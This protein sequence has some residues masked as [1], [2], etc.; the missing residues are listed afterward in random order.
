VNNGPNSGGPNSGLPTLAVTIVLYTIGI[1]LVMTAL[2]ILL[3][4]FNLLTTLPNDVLVALVLLAIGSGIIGGLQ[5]VQRKGG[6]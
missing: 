3:K 2:L 6:R 4:A 5:S 1:L